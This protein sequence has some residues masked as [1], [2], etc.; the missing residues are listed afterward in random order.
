MGRDGDED[1]RCDWKAREAARET[2]DG[3]GHVHARLGDAWTATVLDEQ[4]KRVR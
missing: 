1:P 3:D 2:A 4:R